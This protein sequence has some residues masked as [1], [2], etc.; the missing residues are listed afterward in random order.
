MI[1]MQNNNNNDTTQ[2]FTF[3]SSFDIIVRHS[4]S[5]LVY[6]LRHNGQLFS[7]CVCERSRDTQRDILSFYYYANVY[8]WNDLI[9]L[10]PASGVL[11][12]VDSAPYFAFVNCAPCGAHTY[13]ILLFGI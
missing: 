12:R 9:K 2:Q 7:V 6:A 4:Q 3:S 13:T 5:D 11:C 10:L 1:I 8:T